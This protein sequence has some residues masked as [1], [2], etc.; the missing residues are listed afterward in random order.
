MSR[1]SKNALGQGEWRIFTTYAEKLESHDVSAIE[2]IIR[3]RLSKELEAYNSQRQLSVSAASKLA[4]EGLRLH[5]GQSVSYVITRV[6]E[7][8]NGQSH[9]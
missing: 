9:S 6:R 3:R 2:L 8:W 7:L 1:N 4:R 5:A